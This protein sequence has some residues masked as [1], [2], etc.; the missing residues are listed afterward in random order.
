MKPEELVNDRE[1]ELM[2][3]YYDNRG[4]YRQLLVDVVAV[5][6]K[7]LAKQGMDSTVYMFMDPLLTDE[8]C[9]VMRVMKLRKKMYPEEIAKKCGKSLKDVVRICLEIA[10]RGPIE[11]HTDEK[12]RDWFY[13]PQ[14]CV[15]AL[16]WCMIGPMFKD[17]PEQALLFEHETF[18]SFTGNGKFLPM[19]NHGVH[20]TIP[21][22]SALEPDVKRMS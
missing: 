11:V 7:A 5:Y 19:T 16:E 12:G 6:D 15:G 3:P 13:V 22:E 2:Q 9:E 4:P 20:R 14:L 10:D 18:E 1:R 8:M 21:I 17:H